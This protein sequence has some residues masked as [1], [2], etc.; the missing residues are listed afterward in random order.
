MEKY[1]TFIFRK[2]RSK[3]VFTDENENII[4]EKHLVSKEL[5]NFFKNET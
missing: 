2:I 5:N 3:I 1:I 4:T